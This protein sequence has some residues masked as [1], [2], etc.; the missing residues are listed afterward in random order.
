[1]SVPISEM[2]VNTS[3][4]LKPVTFVKSIPITRLRWARALKLG[5][6]LLFEFGYTQIPMANPD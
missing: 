6:F 4:E 2:I 5:L 1:M 3:D